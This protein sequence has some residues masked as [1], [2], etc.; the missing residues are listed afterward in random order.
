MLIIV[1]F[2]FILFSGDRIY[3]NNVFFTSSS[4]LFSIALSQ[5]NNYCAF[6]LFA[7]RKRF[8][9][10]TTSFLTEASSVMGLIVGLSPGTSL[11]DPIKEAFELKKKVNVFYTPSPIFQICPTAFN[12][13]SIRL[14]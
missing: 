13:L 2:G 10:P 14:T 8:V 3:R 9:I 4:S 1:S 7:S 6:F 12:Y 5:S 11:R